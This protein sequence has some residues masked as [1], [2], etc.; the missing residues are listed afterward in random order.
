MSNTKYNYADHIK[1]PKSMGVS[2]NGNIST[3]INDLNSIYPYI[4]TLLYGNNVISSPSKWNLYP[5]GNNYFIKS[6]TCG[7]ESSQECQ[8]QSRYIYVRNVPTGEIPCMGNFKPKTNLKGL[9][10]GLI[11]D[12]VDIN[13]FAIFNNIRG[14][15]AVVND[16]CIK[17]TLS[18]GPTSANFP[19]GNS[20]ETRCSPP[21][22]T[23]ACLPELFTNYNKKNKKN[24]E[25]YIFVF[26]LLIMFLLIYR[27]NK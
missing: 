21:L 17:Q 16:K 2:S 20:K 6:G 14:K 22:K 9:V 8:G 11:E 19:N 23:P 3:S 24:H 4:D 25:I 12:T 15:G 27:R 10:P 5:L 18:V 13:P 1:S 26:F 7:D